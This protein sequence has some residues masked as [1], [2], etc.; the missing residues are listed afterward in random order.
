MRQTW[1]HREKK[2]DS[3]T[4]DHN[5]TMLVYL[6]EFDR[7]DDTIEREKQLKNWRRDKKAWLIER[8]NPQWLDLAH[9]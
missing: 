1:D 2:A 4:R 5:I 3:F 7:A 9:D 8:D 6:E